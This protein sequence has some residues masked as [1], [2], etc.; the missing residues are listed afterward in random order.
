MK[1]TIVSLILFSFLLSAFSLPVAFAQ[2]TILPTGAEEMD[3]ETCMTIIDSANVLTRE[4]RASLMANQNCMGLS[5]EPCGKEVLSC[6]IKTGNI[7]LWMVPFYITNI[8]EFLINIVGIISVLFVI[9]GG[10]YYAWGG[11]TED[12]EKGKKTVMYALI[13]LALSTMAWIIVNIIQTQ[14]TA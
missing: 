6:G 4:N 11:L 13:G 12:K 1:K 5:T 2:G 3:D 10:Y 8:V 7:H 14:L 9:L